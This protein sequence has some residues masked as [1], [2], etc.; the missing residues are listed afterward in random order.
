VLSN[1]LRNGPSSADFHLPG[2]F[3][4]FAIL[5]FRTAFSSLRV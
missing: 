5:T 1:G 3:S 2:Y 4:F